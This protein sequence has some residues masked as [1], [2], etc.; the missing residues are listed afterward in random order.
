MNEKILALQA[1]NGNQ[2]ALDSLVRIHYQSIYRYFVRKLSDEQLALDMTQDTF[3]K[4][5][6][7]IHNYRPL[8]NFNTYLFTIAHNLSVDY[9]RKKKILLL[10]DM[11]MVEEMLISTHKE[12]SIYKEKIKYILNCLNEKQRESIVLY[13]YHELKYTQIAKILKIPVSTVKSR[14]RVGLATCK[15]LWE[16]EE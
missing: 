7:N 10:E 9:Y 5:A 4:L 3:V 12:E 15:K 14:V 8:S 13:Y 11:D 6:R 16:E 1:K 2:E